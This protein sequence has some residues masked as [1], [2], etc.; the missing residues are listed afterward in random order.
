[1]DNKETTTDQEEIVKLGGNI[2]LSGFRSLDGGTI[3]VLKKMIGNYA[4][5]F[6]DKSSNFELLRLHMKTIHKR[7]TSKL[8]EVHAK[9]IDNGKHATS[10]ITDRNIFIAVDSVLKKIEGQS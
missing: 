10:E 5:K 7:E 9:L 8:F 1:M 6:S 3:I 2:E 4:K